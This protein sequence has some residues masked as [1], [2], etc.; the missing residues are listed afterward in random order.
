MLALLLLAGA[1]RAQLANTDPDWTETEAPPPP[2]LRTHGLIPLE[3]PG[4]T[5]RFGIDPDSIAVSADHVVRYVVIAQGAGGA[6]NGMYEGL[7]CATGEVKV[8][9]RYLPGS[10]WTPVRDSQW[11]PLHDAQFRHSR[12]IARSGACIGR[13]TSGGASEILREL[14]SPGGRGFQPAR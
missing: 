7:R 3:V 4:S 14:K 8:Y 11:R 6:V 2:A 9:A 12:E 5:L 13:G 10:K 1:A